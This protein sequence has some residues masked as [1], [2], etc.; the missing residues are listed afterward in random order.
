MWANST[1]IVLH[2]ATPET[3]CWTTL[4]DLP[5]VG[6]PSRPSLGHSRS[7]SGTRAPSVGHLFA[8]DGRP[9]ILRW[10]PIW[11]S[12]CPA[13]PMGIAGHPGRSVGPLCLTSIF[14]IRFITY[15]SFHPF[16]RNFIHCPK[17]AST[18][19]KINL[20]LRNF[21]LCLQSAPTA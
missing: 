20:L 17:N 9:S 1:Y 3:R 6:H 12:V 10:A 5:S 21:I 13:R 19:Q 11:V 4:Q 15:G 18:F 16:S 2:W 8:S 14:F 7:P